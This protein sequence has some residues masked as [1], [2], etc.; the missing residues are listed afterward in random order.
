MIRASEPLWAA[1]SSESAS[2]AADLATI[3]GVRAATPIGQT[4]DKS[5][6]GSGQ[7]LIDGI[8]YDEYAGIARITIRTKLSRV[9]KR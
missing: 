6:S 9:M 5:D 2:H 4:F 1:L 8:E 7:R 3:P